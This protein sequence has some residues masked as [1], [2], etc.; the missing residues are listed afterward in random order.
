MKQ[1]FFGNVRESG[2]RSLIFIFQQKAED[3]SVWYY[4]ISFTAQIKYLTFAVSRME[5]L[6]SKNPS[7]KLHTLS[8]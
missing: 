5:N 7:V 8:L 4:R 2:F 3:R 1:T 6:L